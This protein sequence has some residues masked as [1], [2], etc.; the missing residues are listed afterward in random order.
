M[1]AC[2]AGGGGSSAPSP[3]TSRTTAG[4]IASG[5]RPPGGRRR[6]TWRQI[7]ASSAFSSDTPASL[8]W[9]RMTRRIASGSKPTSPVQAALRHASAVSEGGGPTDHASSSRTDE[10][11]RSTT[12]A[13]PSGAAG[14]WPA[15]PARRTPAAASRRRR[16]PATRRWT[17][18]LP[19]RLE[20]RPQFSAASRSSPA[21]CDRIQLRIGNEMGGGKFYGTCNLLVLNP[22]GRTARSPPRTPRSCRRSFARRG[23]EMDCPARMASRVSNRCGHAARRGSRPQERSGPEGTPGR[24]SRRDSPSRRLSPTPIGSASAA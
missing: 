9:L 23:P 18:S 10:T 8:V 17:G 2:T 16:R 14:D 3:N 19:V 6:T 1:A 20:P 12:T 21:E 4:V 5:S 13:G 24:R 22:V 11:S 7:A 15:S